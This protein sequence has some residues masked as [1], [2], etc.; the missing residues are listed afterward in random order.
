MRASSKQRESQRERDG[1]SPRDA[2][3]ADE[4]TA[5]VAELLRLQHAVG[6]AAVARLL[7]ASGRTNGAVRLHRMFD[8]GNRSVNTLA[9]LNAALASLPQLA[10]GVQLPLTVANFA[11]GATVQTVD[12]AIAGSSLALYV[13]ID[14]QDVISDINQGLAAP[15]PVLPPA[16]ATFDDHGYKHFGGKH[17]VK[18][19]GAQWTLSEQAAQTAMVNAIRAIEPH[20]RAHSQPA[21]VT[22]FYYTTF[23]TED[24]GKCEGSTTTKYTIQIDYDLAGNTVGYHGYPEKA[25]AKVGLGYFGNTKLWQV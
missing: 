6:N 19:G 22:G 7:A 2:V 10:G 15:V 11:V 8:P 24:V 4:A 20:L 21:G 12:A 1:R 23:H 16:T 9:Q 25:S 5:P 14:V 3:A 17:G 18:Q 13:Y